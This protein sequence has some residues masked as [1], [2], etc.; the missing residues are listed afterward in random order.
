MK[1]Y[2]YKDSTQLK[3]TIFWNEIKHMPHFCA[4]EVLAVGMRKFYGRDTFPCISTIDLLIKLFYPKW[5]KS[6]SDIERYKNISKLINEL[7]SDVTEDLKQSFIKNKRSILESCK[8]LIESEDILL[9]NWYDEEIF[10]NLYPTNDVQLTF[11][12][13]ILKKLLEQIYIDGNKEYWK[14][15][16]I[17]KLWTKSRM[18]DAIHNCI[19][20]E[21]ENIIKSSEEKDLNLYSNEDRIFEIFNEL[22]DEYGLFCPSE[23]ALKLWNSDSN[24]ELLKKIGYSA[25]ELE[26]VRNK[27]TIEN[28][29]Y[30]TIVIHGVYRLNP[31]HLRLLKELDKHYEVIILNC[32]NKDFNNIYNFWNDVY[33]EL[34]KLFKIPKSNIKIDNSDSA[35]HREIGTIFGEIANGLNDKYKQ[36]FKVSRNEFGTDLNLSSDYIDELFHYNNTID[37]KEILKN[38]NIIINKAET[39]DEIIHKANL[40]NTA[41]GLQKELCNRG[42]ILIK[43]D[44]TMQF[45]NK[46]SNIFDQ[47][48]N[49]KGMRSVAR[50]KE[51]FY[52]AKGTD[53]NKIFQVFYPDEFGVKPFLSY[54]IGQF[55]YAIH[56]MWDVKNQCLI[57]NSRDL[58]ECLNLDVW[59]D[60]QP[61]EIFDSL[62]CYI[63]ID[64]SINGMKVNEFVDQIKRLRDFKENKS[65]NELTGLSYF[66]LTTDQYNRFI[67]VIE[68][69]EKIAKKVFYSRLQTSKKHF[70]DLLQILNDE[71]EWKPLSKEEK[72]LI[73]EIKHN[74]SSIH[75]EIDKTDLDTIRDTMA[76]YL[77]N[78]EGTNIN[79]LVRDLDQLE[80]DIL[81]EA[82][83]YKYD[84]L[85]PKCYHFAMLS[86][87]NMIDND[88][89]DLP[90]PLSED[91]VVA[92]NISSFINTVYANNIKY[93]RC[94]LF[95]GLYYLLNN[96]VISVK[97]SYIEDQG[98]CK[99]TPYYILNMLMYVWKDL[100]ETNNKSIDNCRSSIND[101]PKGLF[102]VDK[103]WNEEEKEIFSC[104]PYKFMYGY[105]INAPLEHYKSE[106][107]VRMYLGEVI[108]YYI[109]KAW[110][111]IR[112]KNP[113]LPVDK[114]YDLLKSWTKG[115]QVKNFKKSLPE[116][117]M[118]IC[119]NYFISSEINKMIEDNLDYIY[120]RKILENRYVYKIDS[121]L[122]HCWIGKLSNYNLYRMY[123]DR[124]M[125]IR[126]R[127][128]YLGSNDYIN[129]Y[130]LGLNDG[131]DFKKG[132]VEIEGGYKVSEHVCR[133]CSYNQICCYQYRLNPVH[134]L[135]VEED[136]VE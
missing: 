132:K 5:L 1:I 33:D 44:S 117:L 134:I 75:D 39:D 62:R 115:D 8:Y 30:N 121:G 49:D 108:K 135:R 65:V 93:K 74:L 23:K 130:I 24:D 14:P 36:F 82:A 38:S 64:K 72:K 9:E 85:R 28:K 2:T 37:V 119:G 22:F 52:G 63:G 129:K 56:N 53:M 122:Y 118:P 71:K 55:I 4:A 123:N 48:K 35:N 70:I 32:Y 126:K 77:D 91:F 26:Y 99:H 101:Y 51:Q 6:Y 69:I 27:A 109:I 100:D 127:I 113:N 102:K 84:N 78:K 43:Y 15:E 57:L 103:K 110:I 16:W 47:T 10:S 105:I 19:I 61:L 86:N 20:K 11:K 13:K 54:P 81:S 116:V 128:N 60:I 73:D 94:L 18:S 21:I 98:D 29:S 46:V 111:R 31:I 107:Q 124:K 42:K 68:N 133:Y 80:G 58:V 40:M 97:L 83:N 12:E 120:N 88:V 96:P 76:Y 67:K 106:L 136:V 114:K 89:E 45:V 59:H 131:W 66:T 3:D 79:W 34:I 17:D 112:D 125:D 41:Q 104:C 95:Q 87:E 92:K 90:W 7:D 50:M 25:K